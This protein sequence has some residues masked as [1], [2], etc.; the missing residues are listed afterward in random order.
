MALFTLTSESVANLLH[1]AAL[2]PLYIL[3]ATQKTVV[4]SANSVLSTL[5]V[6]SI[7]I[8][9]AAIENASSIAAGRCMT[10]YT[11]ENTQ[12]AGTG[13]PISNVASIAT[14]AVS[15]LALSVGLETL[16]HPLDA[17]LTWLQGCV[18]GLQDV[19]ETLDRTRCAPTATPAP[20][21]PTPHSAAAHPTRAQT[22]RSAG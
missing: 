3:I 6:N 15:T 18:L 4:C 19:V 14:S 12:G 5:G 20:G 2:G 11:A 21:P 16:L 1:Q 9:D 13:V 7:V 10:Q 17:T 22:S 8:G